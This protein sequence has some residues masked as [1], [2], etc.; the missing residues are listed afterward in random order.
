M[1]SVLPLF[2]LC[3]VSCA[4]TGEVKPVAGPDVDE[5]GV[6][7]RL[8]QTLAALPTCKADADVGALVLTPTFCTEKRCTTAC[9]NACGWNAK[10][11]TAQGTRKLEAATVQQALGLKDGALE[12]EVRAWNDALAGRNV[13]LAPTCLVR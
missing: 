1:R 7:A 11:E 8:E 3:A 5:G 10:L 6:R 2:V 13:G 9:C 4:T 12:C